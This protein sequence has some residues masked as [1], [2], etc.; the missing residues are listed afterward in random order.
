MAQKSILDRYLEKW[1]KEDAARG[2]ELLLW[3]KA[4][5]KTE[6]IGCRPPLDYNLREWYDNRPG[7]GRGKGE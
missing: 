3:P 2:Q 6:R 5:A 4:E 7:G 1:A